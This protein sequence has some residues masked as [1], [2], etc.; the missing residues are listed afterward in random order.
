MQNLLIRTFFKF[1]FLFFLATSVKSAPLQIVSGGNSS[2]K[3][4]VPVTFDGAR[5]R[6]FLDT[7]SAATI[8]ANTRLFASYPKIDELRFKGA[9]AIEQSIDRIQ[10]KSIQLDDLLLKNPSV[11]RANYPKAETTLGIDVLNYQP[12][13]ISTKRKLL[14]LNPARPAI[15]ST[16]LQVSP[17]GLL[18]V[19]VSI[20]TQR[21]YALWDTGAGI[22]TVD[23]SFIQANP[24]DFKATKK[25]MQGTDGA[26][27]PLLVQLF[28]ANKIDVGDQ[29][30]ENLYV[31]AID[32]SV[33]RR[34]LAE[35]VHA[36]I[37]FN[38]INKADW[39][40]D[41]KTRIWHCERN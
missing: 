23:R 6:T 39:Y 40:F 30:F 31:A 17:Q 33:L 13:S 19:P 8:V 41:A 22:T 2:G 5:L 26:G 3:I 4:Y 11:G 15:P 34:G 9:T 10:L 38:L 25:F 37:G 36:V 29:T 20:G 24:D 21:F 16:T 18:S 14:S 27:K 28:R 7:G 32:L 35:N 1:F 12:F